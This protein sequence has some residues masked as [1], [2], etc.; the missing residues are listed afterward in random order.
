[1]GT[2]SNWT[3]VKRFRNGHKFLVT[4]GLGILLLTIAKFVGTTSLHWAGALVLLVSAWF[5]IMFI[6]ERLEK[7][8]ND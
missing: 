4:A 3:T 5:F 6:F 7:L 1:M 2:G 8:S